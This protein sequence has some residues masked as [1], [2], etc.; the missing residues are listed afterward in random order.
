MKAGVKKGKLAK[1]LHENIKEFKYLG[2]FDLTLKM[3]FAEIFAEIGEKS[4]AEK[5]L[6]ECVSVI[7][8]IRE[9]HRNVMVTEWAL[10]VYST[11]GGNESTM[12]DIVAD[13]QLIQRIK[14]DNYEYQAP[15]VISRLINIF[16]MT[17]DNDSAAECSK[18]LIKYLAN[19]VDI[20]RKMGELNSISENLAKVTDYE[21]IKIYVDL[22][23]SY[24][25]SEDP[26]WISPRNIY[27]LIDA[28]NVMI[29]F[30]K[31]EEAKEVCAKILRITALPENWFKD[32]EDRQN[33]IELLQRIGSPEQVKDFYYEYH[34]DLTA[35][36]DTIFLAGLIADMGVIDDALIGKINIFLAN[37]IPYNEKI[38]SEYLDSNN[39]PAFIAK[40]KRNGRALIEEGFNY[41]N[42]ADLAIAYLGVIGS[43]IN[44]TFKEFNERMAIIA[45]FDRKHPGYFKS[46]FGKE[47][48][49]KPIQ[50]SAVESRSLDFGDVNEAVFDENFNELKA[51]QKNIDS[52]R[53]I[54]ELF[55]GSKVFNIRNL[56]FHL[57]R[58]GAMEIGKIKAGERFK[59]D[60]PD[61][62]VMR[63]VI[64][65]N[66]KLFYK[67]VFSL[68]K[69]RLADKSISYKCLTLMRD[70][71][72]SDILLE[73]RIALDMNSTDREIMINTFK[74]FYEDY[75][76]HLPSSVGINIDSIK[77]RARKQDSDAYETITIRQLFDSL[78]EKVYAEISKVKVLKR[79]AT[80]SY[81][82]IPQGFLSLF[83]GRAG[84]TDCSFDTDKPKGVPFTRAMH[85]DSHYYF[86]YKGKELK[87]YIGMMETEAKDGSKVL[88]IDTIQS[89]SLDGEELLANLF[90]Q[91]NRQA[92]ELGCVGIA[93]SK[94]L[95]GPFNFD[96]SETIE[97]MPSY[98]NGKKINDLYPLHGDSWRY[99]F[100]LY[101]DDT[102]N[103]ID[104]PDS[105][106]LIKT[107]P[108]LTHPSTRAIG[109]ALL[110]FW[111]PV[112]EAG[113]VAKDRFIE[114]WIAPY[115]VFWDIFVHANFGK[116]TDIQ[117]EGIERAGWTAV[118]G[119]FLFYVLHT[120]GWVYAPPTAGESPYKLLD[121][122]FIKEIIN[123]EPNQSRRNEF[124]DMTKFMLNKKED[125]AFE[126]AFKFSE[127]DAMT[128]EQRI[129]EANRMLEPAPGNTLSDIAGVSGLVD[130]LLFREQEYN[131]F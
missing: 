20:T 2:V 76:T 77:G 90:A 9:I 37:D 80:D 78:S 105:F 46:L 131:N 123:R 124:V 10:K 57:V 116:L 3:G 48:K 113:R 47:N 1:I 64:F 67:V 88:L 40:L 101:G 6:V 122:N 30:G 110:F 51:I 7:N 117:L 21:N 126:N 52:L 89:P 38:I 72:I 82:L 85:E 102:Y 128:P 125:P 22:A 39:P 68:A 96:N 107:A 81:L 73:R 93:L 14:Q 28:A 42:A 69:D 120:L 53:W 16:L 100:A 60:F 13:N 70:L 97:N 129:A 75:K 15:N 33:I 23:I 83:R 91:L 50:V 32:V 29:N 112:D 19:P 31:L 104:R 106:V 12:K 119:I 27:A 59:I 41:E 56:Y 87:G 43:V 54:D 98:K 92:K 35:T 45:A 95:D 5:I 34:D 114:Q 71:I 18:L 66:P 17:G 109:N 4:E 11:I 44:I 49:L 108:S 86:V 94:D 25:G 8:E 24:C 79:Q 55:P 58:A 99:F 127:I 26:M 111:R 115:V 103:S 62:R 65:E 84:I 61:E 36:S 74:L 118:A 130:E 121:N 63:D